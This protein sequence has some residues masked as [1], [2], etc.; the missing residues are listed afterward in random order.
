MSTYSLRRR[1]LI[2]FGFSHW[3]SRCSGQRG[4]RN[5]ARTKK[6][7]LLGRFL[8]MKRTLRAAIGGHCLKN[9]LAI[10]VAHMSWVRLLFVV[11]EIYSYHGRV[12][13]GLLGQGTSWELR[14][15]PLSFPRGTPS[16]VF[17]SAH[18]TGVPYALLAGQ[19]YL[20]SRSHMWCQ[21]LVSSCP[22]QSLVKLSKGL[23]TDCP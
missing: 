5:I 12:S 1:V 4:V 17:W 3:S 20:G 18:N 8:A 9:R 14:S 6:R 23:G 7:A 11:Y 16:F 22:V 13:W 10:L 15:D 2:R 19:Q 21:F